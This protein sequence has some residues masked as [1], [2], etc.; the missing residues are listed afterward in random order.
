M[1]RNKTMRSQHLLSSCMAYSLSFKFKSTLCI[2]IKKPRDP[3]VLYLA[4][5][6][7]SSVENW[8]KNEGAHL[9]QCIYIRYQDRAVEG[10]GML[11]EG[12]KDATETPTPTNLQVVMFWLGKFSLGSSGAVPGSLRKM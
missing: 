11:R 1:E 4:S 8:K 5:H 7:A 3:V 6:S 9:Y 2:K 12:G 10:W